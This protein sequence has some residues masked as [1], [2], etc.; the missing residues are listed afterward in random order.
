[1][2]ITTNGPGAANGWRFYRI[3]IP[4]AVVCILLGAVL[5]TASGIWWTIGTQHDMLSEL[6]ALRGELTEL[7]ARYKASTVRFDD[8]GKRVEGLSD[9]E[10]DEVVFA[11]GIR[12]EL[13][14]ADA[15]IRE[16]LAR[17]EA[18]QAPFLASA[19]S[20]VQ[21]DQHAH[22]LDGRAD[23]TDRALEQIRNDIGAIQKVI[24]ASGVR[25]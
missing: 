21:V 25:R 4:Q 16:R 17:V 6:H 24:G 3:S 19:A 2:S 22:A 7:E 11:S 12:R 23:A 1:M 14:A 9:A 5:S 15:V 13:E 20:L 8:M 10:K 18:V